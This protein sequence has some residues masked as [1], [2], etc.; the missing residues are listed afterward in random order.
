MR[1]RA[2]QGHSRRVAAHIDED[3][4]LERLTAPPPVCVH[5]TYLR[6]LDSIRSQGLR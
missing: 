2:Q 6:H 1:I 5:G 4:L 3:A